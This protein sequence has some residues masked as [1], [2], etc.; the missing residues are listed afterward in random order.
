MK[1][2]LIVVVIMIY[3]PYSI[4]AFPIR[5]D[6][7]AKAT[8][9]KPGVLQELVGASFNI[10]NEGIKT[11]SNI[12]THSISSA[13]NLVNQSIKTVSGVAIQAIDSVGNVAG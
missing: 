5:Y 12:A 6:P 9:S 4:S 10:A 3:E 2:L 8:S 1:G 13:T 7:T 11:T